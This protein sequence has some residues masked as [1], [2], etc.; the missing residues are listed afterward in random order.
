MK[1]LHPNCIHVWAPPYT[2]PT[3]LPLPD[4]SGTDPMGRGGVRALGYPAMVVAWLC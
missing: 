2:K 4:I 3:A 1:E